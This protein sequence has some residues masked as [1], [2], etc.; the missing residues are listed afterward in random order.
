MDIKISDMDLVGLKTLHDELTKG[1]RDIDAELS[2]S[3]EEFASFR[4]NLLTRQVSVTFN[5]L[6]V[7]ITFLD[8]NGSLLVSP[9]T[10]EGEEG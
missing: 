3:P 1:L 7:R 6:W 4:A 2:I 10:Q 8:R 5:P 9:E